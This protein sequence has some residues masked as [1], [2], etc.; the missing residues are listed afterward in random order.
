[1]NNKMTANL[2]EKIFSYY[3]KKL[4]RRLTGNTSIRKRGVMNKNA[5]KTRRSVEEMAR[6]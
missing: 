3:Q 4:I 5:E 6:L 2:G 1:M